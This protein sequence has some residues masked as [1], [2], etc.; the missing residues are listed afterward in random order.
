MNS[1]GSVSR[2]SELIYKIL[3]YMNFFQASEDGPDG[4]ESNARCPE[5]QKEQKDE[6]VIL[7]S[8]AD[9]CCLRCEKNK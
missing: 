4:P 7:I 9:E 3:R 8:Q 6:V 1:Y 2:V 5:N